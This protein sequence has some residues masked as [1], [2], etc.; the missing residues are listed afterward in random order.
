MS[1]II[2]KVT[3]FLWFD[4]EAEEAANFYTSLLPDSSI[5]GISRYGA[6]GP[7]PE[8]SVMTVSFRLAGLDFTALNGGPV[9]KFNESISFVVRCDDQTELDT[10]WE[11]LLDG[12]K[13]LACGWIKD[14][15]GLAWQIVP[16]VFLELLNS[17]DA[18]AKGRMMAAMMQMIKLD[19]PKLEAAFRGE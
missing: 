10:L 3:P 18:A 16:G 11:K 17:P 14:K 12:G 5:D 13:T 1:K 6:H 8:G 9:Y 2:Q 19:G 15:Y 4:R 7:G